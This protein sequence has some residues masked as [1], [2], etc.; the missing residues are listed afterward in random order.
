M[1]GSRYSSRPKWA[2]AD[3]TFRHMCQW[4]PVFVVLGDRDISDG[5]DHLPQ[6]I[7]MIPQVD[8]SGP[9]PTRYQDAEA[10]E[11]L[12]GCWEHTPRRIRHAQ[13][14]S[15]PTRPSWVFAL[16]ERFL[17][18]GTGGPVRKQRYPFERGFVVL[19]QANALGAGFGADEFTPHVPKVFF[20]EFR[21][22]GL[23][24]PILI[25]EQPPSPAKRRR[26]LSPWE[27]PR[28]G[29]GGAEPP[30]RRPRR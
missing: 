20:P 18:G 28:R 10:A 22:A 4:D 14:R 15:P 26:D 16:I 11:R 13:G 19:T 9:M 27:G 1:I 3:S 6:V 2:A 7:A 29:G 25:P 5:R 21:R 12:R 24:E 23:R 30:A 17:S 8:R